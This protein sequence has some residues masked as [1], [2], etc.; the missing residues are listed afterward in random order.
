MKYWGNRPWTWPW[1]CLPVNCPSAFESVK[2]GELRKKKPEFLNSSNRKFTLQSHLECLIS[3]PLCWCTEAKI[4]NAWRCPN[5]Y[6]PDY[7]RQV[8]YSQKVKEIK[9]TPW[10]CLKDHLFWRLDIYRL[11]F[12]HYYYIPFDNILG[13]SC[14]EVINDTLEVWD[15]CTAEK[16]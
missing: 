1:N 14:K 11:F 8:N 10:Q 6:R 2:M 7:N 5:T 9:K 13:S 3:N 16:G 12:S 15:L 4:Q